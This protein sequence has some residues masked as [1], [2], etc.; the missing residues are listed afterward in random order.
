MF[1]D[2][3]RLDAIPDMH[4]PREVPTWTRCLAQRRQAKQAR[5]DVTAPGTMR[6]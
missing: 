5:H 2:L 6:P 3:A 1:L 4:W